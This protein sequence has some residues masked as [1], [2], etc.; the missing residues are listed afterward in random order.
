[1]KTML[2]LLILA[3]TVS[4]STAGNWFGGSP[5]ANGAAFPGALNGKYVGI[6]TGQNIAGVIGF[7]I[8][9]GAPPFRV[10]TQETVAASALDTAVAINQTITP[11]VLQNYFAIFVEGRTYSG[12]TLAGIDIDSKTVA[13]ALQ[14]Q[15]P[16]G[17]LAF[18]TFEAVGVTIDPV[19]G[20]V[21]SA[22]NNASRDAL[23]IVNR[24]LSG[25]FTA[26]I[27]QN[28]AVFTFQG[29]GQ[30]STPA[31]R[32]TF[33]VSGVPLQPN[34]LVKPPFIPDGT[35][36]N[37][38]VSGIVRTESTAFQISGI[39]TSFLANNPAALADQ[40]ALSGGGG[41]GGL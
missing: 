24:G 4:T 14:G 40:Q 27:N 16:A 30:L 1:M 17:L 9:D 7:A 39:R 5:W 19:T 32:Q 10:N 25:G 34:P 12:V 37:E 22:P 23:S 35:I 11:D 21:V 33:E 20:A 26:N 31:N 2:P 18:D 29:N 36:T 3:V 13:G 28:K 6:V 8:S 15:N 41:G 38:V